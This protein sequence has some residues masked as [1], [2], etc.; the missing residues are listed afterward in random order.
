MAAAEFKE[1]TNE[2]KFAHGEKIED[3]ERPRCPNS[4][5]Y[6]DDDDDYVPSP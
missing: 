2:C 3:C 4:D 5:Y 6:D 1:L